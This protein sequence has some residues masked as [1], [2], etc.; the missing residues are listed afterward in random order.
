MKETATKEEI[1]KRGIK[2]FK[3]TMQD[4][5]IIKELFSIIFRIYRYN[6]NINQF[7]NL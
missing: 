2:G 1:K 3:F 6:I 5:V 7:I 4:L